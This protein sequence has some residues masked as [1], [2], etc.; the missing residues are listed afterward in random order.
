IDEEEVERLRQLLSETIDN[1]LNSKDPDSPMNT[2]LQNL[3]TPVIKEESSDI[4]PAGTPAF[5]SDSGKSA[6]TEVISLLSPGKFNIILS[7]INEEVEKALENNKFH[8]TRQ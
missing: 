3:M 2:Y 6:V 5:Y 4:P 8:E 7:N 1:V